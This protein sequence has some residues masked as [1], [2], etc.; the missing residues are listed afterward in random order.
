MNASDNLDWFALEDLYYEGCRLFTRGHYERAI[1][2]F[3]RV[4]EDT[5]DLWDVADLVEGYYTLPRDQW[6]IRY[7][8]RIETRLCPNRPAE[9]MTAGGVFRQ[10]RRRLATAIAHFFRS[11]KP[12]E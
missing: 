2:Q 4:Y 3:K 10:L 6:I 9:R 11:M 8:P 1:D 5:T 7:R 12:E